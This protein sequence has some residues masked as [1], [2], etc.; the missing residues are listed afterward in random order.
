MSKERNELLSLYSDQKQPNTPDTD[1]LL[2]VIAA[3]LIER[4]YDL[5][6]IR[7]FREGMSR[8]GISKDVEE[9]HTQFSDV[10][11]NEYLH[12][13]ANR[14]GMYDMLPQGLFHEPIHKQRFKDAESDVKKAVDQIKIHRK[15]EF[16]ARKFFQ[17]FEESADKILIEAYLYE[18]RYDR[19]LKNPEFLN[20]Y[21][22][23][24]PLIK[25]LEKQQALFFVHI[26]PVI[27]KIRLNFSLVED[28][29]AS[30]LNVPIEITLI[31]LPAKKADRFFESRLGKSESGVDFVL[32]NSFD[33]G[34]YDLKITVG[35]ISAKRM[36][37][38]LETAKEYLILQELIALFLPANQFVITEFKIDPEDSVFTLSNE[39]N[40]TYLGK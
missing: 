14:E 3:S 33:D 2:E 21:T 39:N 13:K 38:F 36:R 27:H 32:G 9:I 28:A 16:F 17:I 23:Y 20:I 35:P 6:T 37:G 10:D 31:K 29:L 19:K 8:R 25:E 5:D 30:I 15:Q 24:W 7:I 22:Q 26:I 1:Y 34:E 40:S 18:T 12:I 4:G 11:F